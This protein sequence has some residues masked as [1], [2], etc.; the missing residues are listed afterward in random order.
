MINGED[1]SVI[2]IQLDILKFI[3]KRVHM[4]DIYVAKPSVSGLTIDDMRELIL[5]I[6]TAALNF[7]HT[8]G[9]ASG[10]IQ[11]CHQ[12]ENAFIYNSWLNNMGKLHLGEPLGLITVNIQPSRVLMCTRK[13]SEGT[14][15][16]YN[17]K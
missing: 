9:L 13:L 11:V 12:C 2:L 10:R 14:K 15:N 3:W 5:S 6:I 7:K 1:P 17:R 16:H 4:C 8:R